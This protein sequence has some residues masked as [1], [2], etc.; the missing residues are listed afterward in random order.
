MAEIALAKIDAIQKGQEIYL[1]VW[2]LFFLLPNRVRHFSILNK[3]YCAR[4]QAMICYFEQLQLGIFRF[5]GVCE[6]T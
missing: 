3:M 1:C 5:E 6:R 4:S 2:F